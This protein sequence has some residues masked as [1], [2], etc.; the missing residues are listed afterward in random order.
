MKQILK[1]ITIGF[2]LVAYSVTGFAQGYDPDHPTATGVNVM[3]DVTGPDSN[4][5]Y[6]VTLE[7]FAEGT[8]AVTNQSVPTDIILVLDTSS[9]MNSTNY[10]YKGQTMSRLA[11]MR[12]VVEEFAQTIYDNDASARSVDPSYAGDRIAI[13][14]YNRNATMVTDNWVNINQVVSKDGDTYSGSLITQIRGI[15]YSSGTRPDH[16]L[17]MAIDRLLDG[18]PRSA[19][20]DANLVVLMFTDGYPTDQSG[21]GLGDASQSSAS[22]DHFDY[23]FAAKALYFGSRIKKDYGATLYTI[24]LITSVPKPNNPNGTNQQA[25]QWRNYCR[26][27]A[28]CDWISSNYPDADFDPDSITSLAIEDGTYTG[29]NSSTVYTGNSV[30]RPWR[31]DWAYNS[32][33]DVITL[34]DF[35]PGT[36][37]SGDDVPEDGYS[38]VVDD[39]TDFGAIFKS[40]AEASAGSATPADQTTQIR[41]VVSNSFVLPKDFDASSVTIKVW[42]IKSDASDWENET[43]ATGVTTVIK[44]VTGEDGEVR[45]ELIIEGFDFSADGEKDEHGYY[46]DPDDEGNW[47]GKRYTDRNNYH[48]AGK[49][50]VIS[51][52]IKANGEATGGDGT[53]TNH[54]DSGVYLLV[55]DEAGNPVLDEQGNKQ[56]TKV[57]SYPIP[58]TNLPL[59]IKI[60]KTGLKHGESAT[61]EIHR[62]MALKNADGSYVTNALGKPQPDLEWKESATDEV[63]GWHNWSKVILTNKGEDGAEVTKVLYALDPAYVYEVTEDDWGWSYTLTGTGTALNTSEVEINP[64]NFKNTLKDNVVKHAEAVTINHFQGTETEAYEEHYKS[65]GTIPKTQNQ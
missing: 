12:L 15:N 52:K 25:W 60:T 62:T 38:Q 20:E 1:Y 10:T 6:T 65:V 49:K 45:K 23:P 34:A 36:K 14:T 28:M 47:V 26:V 18:S 40:I 37:A 2:A 33:G 63:T 43:T 5:D 3:K 41:D 55:K 17:E 61:F 9:S 48:Y 27:L 4:N 31:N 19:R 13:I 51:F 59:I 54:P 57:V 22:T 42:D 32:N 11:A 16:G 21:S 53:N 46:T 44:D 24:G 7:T 35:T 39:A 56:Y 58:N 8:A 50:L 29:R 64:F 30:V